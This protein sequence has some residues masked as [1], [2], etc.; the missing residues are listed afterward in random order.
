MELTDRDAKDLQG[1]SSTPQEPM[2]K[3][4]H[5]THQASKSPRNDNGNNSRSNCYR[6]RGKHSPAICK[7]KTEKCH[8]CGK[9]GHI[10][11]LCRARKTSHT[12]HNNKRKDMFKVEEA[13]NVQ[14]LLFFQSQ[15]RTLHPSVQ[16]SEL[17]NKTCKW[18]W[19]QELQ[20]HS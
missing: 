4:L 20:Y 16:Q 11:K 1:S 2:H 17:I 5:W 10:A 7:F 3:L 12:S 15:I 6:C 14:R 13:L 19:I 18:K 9:L 8:A